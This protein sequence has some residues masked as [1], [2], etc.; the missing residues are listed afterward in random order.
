[1]RQQA[2]GGG[3]GGMLGGMRGV[4][5]GSIFT[6]SVDNLTDENA[7]GRVYDHR[8][9]VRLATYLRPYKKDASVSVAAVLVY[10]LCNV[11]IP[12]ADDAGHQ[13]GH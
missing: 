7:E 8:V 5:A 9:I 6:A 11:S 4:Q 10:T 12:P 1:M 2:P 13:W 3:F